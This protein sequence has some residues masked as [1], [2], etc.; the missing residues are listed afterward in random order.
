MS[1]AAHGRVDIAALF[2]AAGLDVNARSN[3]SCTEHTN[4]ERTDEDKKHDDSLPL[5]CLSFLSL[6]WRDCIDGC[7]RVRLLAHGGTAARRR[8]GH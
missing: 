8:V 2:V 4:D 3:V 7:Y 5:P 1:A 6:G